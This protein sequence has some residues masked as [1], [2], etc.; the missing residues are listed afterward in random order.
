MLRGGFERKDG[1]V[2][3]NTITLEGRQM[4]L[5]AAFRQAPMTLHAALVFGDP[6]LSLVEDDLREPTIG[7]NGYARIP[8][9]PDMANWP[10]LDTEGGL[11]RVVS[12]L[13][14]WAAVDGP[15]DQEVN[16]IAIMLG[17]SRT[18][19]RAVW[20]VG[21]VWLESLVIDTDTPLA[22]RQFTYAVRL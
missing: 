10:T 21:S 17:D 20:S 3:P 16:R 22:Q 11:G 1:M 4:T 5:A 15:F 9:S 19:E 6:G 13:M 2:T 14:T 7:V 12:K 18:P 8:V